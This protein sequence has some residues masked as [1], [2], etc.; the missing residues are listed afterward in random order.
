MRLIDADALIEKMQREV[1]RYGSHTFISVSEVIKWINS[2]ADQVHAQIEMV[3]NPLFPV[4]KPMEKTMED[5]ELILRRE[6]GF[7]GG[8]R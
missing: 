1:D 8:R 2:E 7:G 6:D 5:G 4:P 3:I